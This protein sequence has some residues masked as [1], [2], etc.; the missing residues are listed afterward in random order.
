MTELGSATEVETATVLIGASEWTL[1]R[2]VRQ[3]PPRLVLGSYL[4]VRVLRSRSWR[5]LW[6][7]LV[8]VTDPFADPRAL[9]REALEGGGWRLERIDDEWGTGWPGS[10]DWEVVVSRGTVTRGRAEPER[11]PD[12]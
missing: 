4:S 3:Y 8:E 9:A 10:P 2:G 1:G 11:A 5:T 6:R 7:T 12:D